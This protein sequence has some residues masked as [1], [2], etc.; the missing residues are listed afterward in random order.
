MECAGNG[1]AKLKPRPLS[2]PWLEGAVS[3]AEWTG[4]PVA[5]LLDE[6]GLKPGTVECVFTG[7]DHGTEKGDEH[8]YARSLTAAELRRPEIMIAYEMNGRPLEPQHG[9][10]LR[11]I[12]PGWYGMTSVKWLKRI[13]AVTE[14]F[15]GCQQ[16]TAYW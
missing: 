16:C 10:P 7:A 5:R 14:P 15:A 9:H 8:D 13:E 4:V 12:V 3:T 1:R 2:Q 11:L 6:A